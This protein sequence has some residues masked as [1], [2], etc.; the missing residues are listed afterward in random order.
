MPRSWRS[1][2]GPSPVREMLWKVVP[3]CKSAVRGEGQ[4]TVIGG[5]MGDSER[6]ASRSGL[7]AI[8]IRDIMS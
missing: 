8:V 1:S 2:D 3:E 7:A 5:W 4:S 6:G